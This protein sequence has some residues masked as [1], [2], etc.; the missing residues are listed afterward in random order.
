MDVGR[1]GKHSVCGRK[2]EMVQYQNFLRNLLQ[3]NHY[4]LRNKSFGADEISNTSAHSAR[5]L[6]WFCS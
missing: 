2:P 4:N 5:E 3:R 6:C 1:Q